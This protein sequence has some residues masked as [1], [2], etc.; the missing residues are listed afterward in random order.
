[1]ETAEAALRSIVSAAEL[2]NEA[3]FGALEVLPAPIYFTDANGIVSHYNQACIGFAG[4]IPAVGKDKWC[5]TWKLYTEDGELLPH[6]E[7]PMARAL[8][9]KKPVRGMTAVAE[10]PDGTR[11]NFMPFPTPLF[12]PS[13]ELVGAVNMLIDITHIRQIAELRSQAQKCR[14]LAISV[15]DRRTADILNTVATEYDCKAED[16]DQVRASQ[17]SGPA[18]AIAVS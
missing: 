5:V 15:G 2:G 10:R 4:R 9:T 16:L 8:W 6:V 3:L 1:M 18:W 7:C 17:P 11:V 14:R 13:E 12:G